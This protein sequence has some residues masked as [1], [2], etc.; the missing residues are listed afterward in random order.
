MTSLNTFSGDFGAR[1]ASLFV[2]P[3]LTGCE[4]RRVAEEGVPRPESH[5]AA[6]QNQ[7][8]GREGLLSAP[9]QGWGFPGGR[10]SRQEKPR[11]DAGRVRSWEAARARPG[12]KPATGG[13]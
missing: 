11:G 6:Q 1:V 3:H 4:P 2:K 8:R 13:F 10:L 12:V 7:E 9:Q 5:Q